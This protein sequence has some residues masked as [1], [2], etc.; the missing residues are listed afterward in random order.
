MTLRSEGDDLY[1]LWCPAAG[2]YTERN[3]GRPLRPARGRACP[4]AG[5]VSS[6]SVG[7]AEAL[8]TDRRL[9]RP[10]GP[11]SPSPPLIRDLTRVSA[12]GIVPNNSGCRFGSP[13]GVDLH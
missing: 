11:W 6:G 2:V 9:P 7:L 1:L 13:N 8:S 3:E 5:P 12:I 10:R 4:L